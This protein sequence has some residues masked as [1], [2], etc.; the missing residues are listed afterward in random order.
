MPILVIITAKNIVNGLLFAL[1]GYA[2]TCIKGSCQAASFLDTAKVR[3]LVSLIQPEPW[4]G[5][6]II[7]LG[8]IY[9]LGMSKICR[10][11]SR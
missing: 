9:R 3:S 11:P 8:S 1:I 5:E 2:G 10:L 6:L 4:A 7:D